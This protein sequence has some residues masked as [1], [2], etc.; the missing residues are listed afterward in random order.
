MHTDAKIFW[1]ILH[2]DVD[3]ADVGV[4]KCFM[5][6][7]SLFHSGDHSFCAKVTERRIVNLDMA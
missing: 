5:V 3:S 6:N 4:E 7:A 2:T 1:S